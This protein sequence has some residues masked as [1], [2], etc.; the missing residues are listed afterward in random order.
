VFKLFTMQLV[1]LCCSLIGFLTF[2][3]MFAPVA[4]ATGQYAQQFML[5]TATPIPTPMT[6]STT[7]KPTLILSEPT[8]DNTSPIG[9][10]GTKVDI[11][12][13]GFT[14][15]STISLYT[16]ID[17]NQCKAGGE[18]TQFSSQPVETVQADGTFALYTTWPKNANRPGTAY[19]VCALS[20]NTAGESAISGQ[21]FSVAQKVTV[22]ASTSS[23]NPGDSITLTGD[24][25]FPPQQ[26]QVNIV[27]SRGV[28]NANNAIAS[29]TA[30]PDSNGHFS[31][32]LTIDSNAQPGQYVISVTA[33]NEP[34]LTNQPNNTSRITVTAQATPT[35]IPTPTPILT[36]TPTPTATPMPAGTT[37]GSNGNGGVT[38]LAFMLGGLGLLCV[39]VGGIMF[40]VSKP[41]SSRMQ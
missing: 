33:P 28:G 1:V 10:P 14:P 40:A 15:N 22:S 21:T 37:G 23:V 32:S 12:G 13:Q 19:Y 20:S 24:N 30:T 17:P 18:L 11:T 16:T 41:S 5:A 29:T 36:D 34:T 35:P 27:P 39:I 6:P 4:L 3:F 31:I 9:H 26:L 2:A 7:N 8:M 25:W 38:I